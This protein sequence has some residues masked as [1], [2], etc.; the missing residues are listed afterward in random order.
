MKAKFR[1]VDPNDPNKHIDKWITLSGVKK[2]ED[3]PRKITI[4]FSGN[5]KPMTVFR[6]DIELDD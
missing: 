2:T 4:H 3:D 5:R 1:A 6:A